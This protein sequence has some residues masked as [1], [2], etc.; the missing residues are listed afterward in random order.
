MDS[1]EAFDKICVE[2]QTCVEILYVDSEKL[3]AFL[4]R[5]NGKK[6]KICVF[7]KIQFIP[8]KVIR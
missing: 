6:L 7:K 1:Y 2:F 3:G 5:K 8:L 4:G